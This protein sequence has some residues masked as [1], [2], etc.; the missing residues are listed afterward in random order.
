MQL[1]PL[2]I[3]FLIIAAAEIGDKTQLLAFGFASR[4]P[5]WKVLSAIFFATAILMGLAVIF[6]GAINH[7]IPEF[8]LQLISG[9]VFI[10]FGLWTIVTKEKVEDNKIG[11]GLINPLWIVFSGFFLAEL[12]DKTQLAA[13]ALSAQYGAPF[14]VWLGATSGMMFVNAFIVLAGSWIRKFISEESLKWIGAAAFLIF[15]ILTLLR[16][17]VK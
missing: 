8:Y 10:F 12:G 13:F 5:L 7:L 14:Q 6:G 3:S 1:Y 16:L 15:G 9:I 4:F 11:K 17:F 2:L